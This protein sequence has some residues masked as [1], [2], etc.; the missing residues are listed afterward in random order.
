[1]SA[2]WPAFSTA[3]VGELRHCDARR[4]TGR[5][6]AS[7]R[8]GWT[9]GLPPTSVSSCLD[10]FGPTTS[11]GSLRAAMG[12]F[13][14]FTWLSQ[15]QL[16]DTR[17]PAGCILSLNTTADMWAHPP[18]HSL[19][20]A[21]YLAR[22][23]VVTLGVGLGLA[24]CMSEEHAGEEKVVT[25]VAVQVGKVIKANLRVRIEAYGSVEPEPAGAG[26]PAGAARLAAPVAGIV[27]AVPVKEGQ[28]VETGEVVVRLDDRLASAM[29]EKA[30]HTVV[31]A[32]QQVARQNN[33]RTGNVTS[34]KSVEEAAQQLVVA[35]GELAVAQAQLAQVQLISPLKGIVARISVQPGQAVD[36]N[37][38]V[39]EIVDLK[40]L[41]VSLNVP[42][43]EAMRLKI[44]Q[45]ADLFTETAEAPA[46]KA[47][48]SFVSPVVDSK[49]GVGLVRLTLPDDFRLAARAVR[50]GAHCESR[51]AGPSGGAPGE[52]GEDR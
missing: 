18:E 34:A 8:F 52:R 40:R 5:L 36:Q 31:F 47:S 15:G 4:L 33:L 6:W 19:M 30:Q 16:H 41:V 11:D 14:R 51:T 48:V 7:S 43:D 50:P 24:G 46:G 27:L 38:V 39:A 44:G 37:T 12:P 22:F 28:S 23:A 45:P 32:E 3:F 2:G 9:A 26:K 17:Q 42:A 13:V 20:K 10:A 49:T 21:N 35:R 29:V 1:M 25:E